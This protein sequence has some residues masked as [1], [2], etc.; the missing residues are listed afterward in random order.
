MFI[1]E[2]SY[3]IQLYRLVFFCSLVVSKPEMISSR[4]DADG[5]FLN[6]FYDLSPLSDRSAVDVRRYFQTPD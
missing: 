1:Q 5:I 2:P 6:P 3:S 4:Y